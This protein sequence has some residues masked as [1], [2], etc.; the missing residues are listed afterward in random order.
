MYHAYVRENR[1]IKIEDFIDIHESW[2]YFFDTQTSWLEYNG[3]LDRIDFI[4]KYENLA[5]DFKFIQNKIGIEENTLQL[6]NYNTIRDTYP[7]LDMYDYYR[8]RCFTNPKVVQ[9]VRNRYRKDF[10]NFD[11]GMAL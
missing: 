4:G 3:S 11:Y 9:F 1:K 8:K 5:E 10:K 7:N 6:K 2:D